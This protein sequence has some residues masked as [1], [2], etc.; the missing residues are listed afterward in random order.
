[1]WY[2]ICILIGFLFGYYGHLIL[3][4]IW[5]KQNKTEKIINPK[6]LEQEIKEK[7]STIKLLDLAI[8]QKKEEKYDLVKQNI[9]LRHKN[10]DLILLKKNTEELQKKALEDGMKI[11]IPEK[12]KK[13]MND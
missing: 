3:K 10:E 5:L 4:Q 2:F 12:E 1:M 11:Y 13:K 8:T 7:E 9:N 6:E